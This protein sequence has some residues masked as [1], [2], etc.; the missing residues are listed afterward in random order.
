MKKVRTL[1]VVRK[2][3]VFGPVTQP[4]LFVTFLSEFVMYCILANVAAERS[5]TTTAVLVF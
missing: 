2:A 4:A 5:P 3:L 1:S